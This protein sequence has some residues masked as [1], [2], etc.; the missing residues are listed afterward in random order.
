MSGGS[1]RLKRGIPTGSVRSRSDG[2]DTVRAGE[3][4]GAGAVTTARGSHG[5]GTCGGVLA[6]RANGREAPPGPEPLSTAGG[7]APAAAAVRRRVR[8][9]MLPENGKAVGGA[10]S[11]GDEGADAAG[12]MVAAESTSCEVLVGEGTCWATAVAAAG[13]SA[14]LVPPSE[15]TAKSEEKAVSAA[16]KNPPRPRQ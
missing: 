1:G 15:G 3:A 9:E 16:G 8:V 11:P 2:M 6:R 4:A 12:S 7:A 10:G 14:E 13:S 5:R